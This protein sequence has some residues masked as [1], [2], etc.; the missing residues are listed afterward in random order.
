MST[1]SLIGSLH[2]VADAFRA[3]ADQQQED[4]KPSTRT[5]PT[6]EPTLAMPL[7]H[8]KSSPGVDVISTPFTNMMAIQALD[9]SGCVDDGGSAESKPSTPESPPSMG[10]IARTDQPQPHSPSQA[11]SEARDRSDHDSVHRPTLDSPTT[12]EQESCSDADLTERLGLEAQI[13]LKEEVLL[14]QQL[15]RRVTSPDRADLAQDLLQARQQATRIHWQYERLRRHQDFT[16]Q[17]LESLGRQ[18][19]QC[20]Q[21]QNSGHPDKKTFEEQIS[22]LEALLLAMARARRNL[23]HHALADY[24]A[25]RVRGQKTVVPVPIGA[26]PA[27]FWRRQS[28]V[29]LALALV[30]ALLALFCAWWWHLGVFDEPPNEFF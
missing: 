18:I 16:L 15:L 13:A 19:K 21:Q 22:Q 14:Y 20:V 27:M 2:L 28:N 17:R 26:W 12:I 11:P 6:N 5:S 7:A 30:F 24:H 10:A 1:D 25:P 9:D 3:R 4:A 29:Q 23:N 8:E